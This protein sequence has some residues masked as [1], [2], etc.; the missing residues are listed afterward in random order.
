M[1][2]VT[3]KK[4]LKKTNKGNGNFKVKKKKVLMVVLSPL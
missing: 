3:P 2:Q 4:Y 1:G